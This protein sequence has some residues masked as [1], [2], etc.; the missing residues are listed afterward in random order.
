MGVGVSQ[1]LHSVRGVSQTLYSVRGGQSDSVFSWGV[2]Q[3][4]YSVG[5]GGWGD[6]QAGF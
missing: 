2:S 5:A 4:L 6:G 3:A 1:A